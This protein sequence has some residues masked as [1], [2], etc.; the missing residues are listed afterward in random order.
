MLFG[1]KAASEAQNANPGP[2]AVHT[3]T[4]GKVLFRKLCSDC[5]GLRG[6][7]PTEVLELLNSVPANLRAPS[8][9]YG[10]SS[11][12]IIES[13]QNG[14]GQKMPSFK[15]RLSDRQISAIANYVVTLSGSADSTAKQDSPSE[16]LEYGEQNL[17]DE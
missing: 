5:H 14:H 9:R 10:N 6:E 7:P 12:Q 8:Y 1:A 13:I 4:N 11:G 3:T 16:P 15:N 2:Q 17:E